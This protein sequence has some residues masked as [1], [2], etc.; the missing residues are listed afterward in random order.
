M[1]VAREAQVTRLALLQV[2]VIT[3]V[4]VWVQLILVLEEV[5][6]LVRLVLLEL[7]RSQEMAA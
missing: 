6:A 3:A 1:E 2:K 7:V 5:E 4:M